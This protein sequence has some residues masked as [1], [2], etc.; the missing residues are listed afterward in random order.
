M[1]VRDVMTWEV[2][3]IH[4]DATVEAAAQRMSDYDIG[5]LPVCE[6]SRL[7]GVVTDRDIVV[8]AIAR[9]VDPKSALVRDTMTDHIVCCYEDHDVTEATRLMEE[10]QIRR[11]A[12]LD[13][14]ERLV[15]I[16]TLRDLAQGLRDVGESADVF[17]R[18]SF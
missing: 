3:P 17:R 2:Q 4:P 12:V 10:Q 16:V 11:I 9:G 8:R 18:L 13:R 7:V 15:G 14:R 6:G 1:L 5:V